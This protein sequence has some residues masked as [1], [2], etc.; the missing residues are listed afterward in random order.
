MRQD[1]IF[2]SLSRRSLLLVAGSGLLSLSRAYGF[3]TIKDFWDS[4]DPGFAEWSA[5]GNCKAPHQI[6]LGE[7]RYRGKDAHAKR[8]DHHLFQHQFRDVRHTAAQEQ[9]YGEFAP[10]RQHDFEYAESTDRI[11]GYGPLGK[12]RSRT[13]GAEDQ[14]LP[15]AFAGQIV[16][17]MTGVP[18]TRSDLR[19]AQWTASARELRSRGKDRPPL[20]AATV[21]HT[22]ENV[23]VYLFGFAREALE[24][25]KDTKEVVFITRMGALG[26]SA[27]FNPRDMLYHS[28]LAI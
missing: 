21:Q 16:L 8:P 3:A 27:K 2:P 25:T 12:R 4:K 13:S 6:S 18:L 22:H 9:R 20:E 28:E 1:L 17:G 11:Q 14:F 10:A 7:I 5:E 19:L 15:D 24:L 26:F 23:T